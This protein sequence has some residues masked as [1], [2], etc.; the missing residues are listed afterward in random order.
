M[1]NDFGK[2]FQIM[3]LNKP[4]DYVENDVIAKNRKMKIR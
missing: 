4:K 2:R 3:Q 1:K